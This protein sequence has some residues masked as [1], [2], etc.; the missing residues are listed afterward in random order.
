MSNFE[1]ED[2][3]E[4]KEMDLTLEEEDELDNIV[5]FGSEKIMSDPLL[6]KSEKDYKFVPASSSSSKKGKGPFTDPSNSHLAKA[7]THIDREED[8][9]F[10]GKGLVAKA[11][12]EEEDI[13]VRVDNV[14]K[15][16]LL[17]IEGI[18]ALRGVSLSIRSGEF[19]C[20][21]GTSG[22]GKTRYCWLVVFHAFFCSR[23][24]CSILSHT[25]CPSTAC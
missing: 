22:G 21:F 4:M 5:E 16:Y 1:E 6:P 11:D 9:Y 2:V 24:S 7:F 8:E 20:I 25:C 12:G 17:G 13:I 18:A 15:T 19:I 10:G 3:V 14:H 23:R